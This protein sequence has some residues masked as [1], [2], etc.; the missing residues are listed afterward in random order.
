MLVVNVFVN[1][2]LKN[3]KNRGEAAIK[4]FWKRG[5]SRTGSLGKEPFSKGFPPMNA[6]NLTPLVKHITSVF[7]A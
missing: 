2:S 3:V 6:V 7:F 1:R 5:P 4:K